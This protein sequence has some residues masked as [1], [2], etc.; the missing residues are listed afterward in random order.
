MDY[1]SKLKKLSY[2][3]VVIFV[4][5]IILVNSHVVGLCDC[6]D[7]LGETFGMPLFFFSI[8][9]FIFSLILRKLP[10]YVFRSWWRFTK[11]YFIPTVIL[12]VIFPVTAD[13]MIGPDRE[14]MTWAMAILFLI[15]SVILILYKSF[16]KRPTLSN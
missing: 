8:I 14:I 4:V 9:I 5:A 16:R 6:T 12:I 1:K 7:L 3:S 15:I 11:Y 2:F 13:S 10:E